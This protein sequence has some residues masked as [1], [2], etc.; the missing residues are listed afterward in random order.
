MST[1]RL[2]C[3]DIATSKGVKRKKLEDRVRGSLDNSHWRFYTLASLDKAMIQ[4]GLKVERKIVVPGSNSVF[5]D[6]VPEPAA[7]QLKR[8]ML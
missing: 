2:S 1:L 7:I 4:Y 6:A 5:I 8:N 3:Y